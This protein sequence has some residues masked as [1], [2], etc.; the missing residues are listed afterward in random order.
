MEESFNPQDFF[1][2]VVDDIAANLKLLRVILEP[3]GYSLTFALGGKQAIERVTASKPD[4][5]LLD[6]M[7]PEID[8]LEVCKRLK[9]NAKYADIPIIF[10][11]ASNEEEKLIAAFESGAVDY[12]NKPFKKPELLA[13]IRNHLLLKHTIEKLISMQINLQ[14]ALVKVEKYANTDPL[15][16]ILNRRSLFEIANQEFSRV[17]RY[18]PPFSIFLIDLDH[19]KNVNDNYGHQIGDIALCTVVKD[20]QNTI[21]NVDFLG[22][23]GGEEFMLILPETDGEQALI[24]AERIRKLVASSIIETEKG[25]LKLTLSIGI[26]S[27]D[28][29]DRSLEDMISRADRGVYQA[30]KLGRN[31]CCL[32]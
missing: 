4:L 28:P 2:L 23:Y 21:R 3:V 16:G 11:T 22:R 5:I 18:G 32:L 14:D 8:G 26:T 31:R 6:L 10:L 25:N 29:K 1:I 9:N 19:F 13:R 7:M 12:I 17:Q 20:I 15:T 27:Y 24:L 30:K